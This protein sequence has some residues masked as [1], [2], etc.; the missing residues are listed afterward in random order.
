MRRAALLGLFLIPACNGSCGSSQPPEASAPASAR[1]SGPAPAATRSAAPPAAPTAP[2]PPA[3]PTAAAPVSAEEAA[4]LSCAQRTA[5]AETAL[6]GWPSRPLEALRREG[7]E[8][9]GFDTEGT[10]TDTFLPAPCPEGAHCKPQPPPHVVL[11][12]LDGSRGTF[13]GLT[14][15]A[16]SISIGERLRFSVILCGSR[17]YGGT[18]NEGEIVAITR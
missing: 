17:T 3:A 16:G 12:P 2:E 6:R 10:V 7:R 11:A 8:R 5:A 18:I 9:G 14:P 4:K 13:I 1:P 15:S